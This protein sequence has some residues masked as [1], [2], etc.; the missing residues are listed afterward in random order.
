[1]SRDLIALGAGV[2]SFANILAFATTTPRTDIT[3]PIPLTDV[4][5]RMA[6]IASVAIA[7]I[8]LFAMK[9]SKDGE[10]QLNLSDYITSIGATLI[11]GALGLAVALTIDD[12][13]KKIAATHLLGS[14][15]VET[16][17]KSY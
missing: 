9:Y 6:P 15:L 5:I 10:K 1:M 13:V 2:L 12:A 17:R 8:S 3:F 16:L 4:S 14:I 7:A 11:G